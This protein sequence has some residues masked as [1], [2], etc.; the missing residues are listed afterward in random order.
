[1]TEETR[2][3]HEW[4]QALAKLLVVREHLESMYTVCTDKRAC[5]QLR[6][7]INSST[8][9]FHILRETKL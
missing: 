2:Q 8:R 1:M 3:L 6:D 9:A 4:V 5:E 7:A